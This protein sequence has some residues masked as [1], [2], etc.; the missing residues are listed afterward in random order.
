MSSVQLLRTQRPTSP[1]PSAHSTLSVQQHTQRSPTTAQPKR[2]LL[3]RLTHRHKN[4]KPLPD[5]PQSQSNSSLNSL[6]VNRR[7]HGRSFSKPSKSK[8][9][10]SN[11]TSTPKKE[12][13]LPFKH[14]R[15]DAPPEGSKPARNPN[16]LETEDHDAP[17]FLDTDT[18]N[19]EGIVDGRRPLM[20]PS[21]GEIYEGWPPEQDTSVEAENEE[22]GA[23]D[24]PES[25]LTNR[26][27]AGDDSAPRPTEHDNEADTGTDDDSG[28]MYFMR[29]LRADSTFAVINASLNSTVADIISIMGKKTFFADDLSKYHIVLRKQDTSRQ[30]GPKE[31]PLL[32]QKQLLMMAGY[33]EN[34]DLDDVGREDHGYLCRFTFLPSKMS[35][36]SSLEKDPNFDRTS[37]FTRV[38]L[39]GRNL[40]TIPITLYVKAGEINT[41]NLSRNLTLDIPKDFI[42]TC[43][44]LREIRYCSNEAEKLSPN[45]TFATRLQSL[46]VSNNRL[47]ELD[48]AELDK[49]H[50]LLSL[51]L[52]NNKLRSVP[53]YFGSFRALRSL[54]LSSNSLDSFPETLRDLPTLKDLDISFNQISNLGNLGTL[55]N[56]ERLLATNNKLSGPL[57]ESLANL[58]SLREIDARFNAITNIDVVSQLP[59]LETL[60]L[61][62]NSIS[63]FEGSFH[64]LEVLYLNHNP[65]TKF[66]LTAP[67][68]SL[69]VLNLASA[70]LSQLP[71]TLFPK[72]T[73]LTKL[74]INKNHFVSLSPQFGLLSKL[75]YLSVFKNELSRLPAEIGRLTELR[76]LDVHENNLSILP[77]EI[78]LARKLETLNVSSNVLAEF[79]KPGAT[80]PALPETPSV[81]HT[82]TVGSGPD[83]EELGRLEDFQLRRPSQAS[84]MF[85]NASSPGTT[86][87]KGSI[88]SHSSNKP[89]GIN[90]IPTS[91][92]INTVTPASRKDSTL[93]GRLAATFASSLRHLSLA[94]NRLEDDVF[95]E[96][97]LLSELRI[98]NLSFNQ[99]Y[100]VP[101]R[102]IRRW[103]NLTQ[104]YL[105]GNDLTSIPSEDLE[106]SSKLRVL[107]INNNKFQN[108]PAEIGN[109]HCLATLDVGSN[110]LKYNVSNWPYDWNWNSNRQLRFLNLSGN[111]RLEIKPAI[112]APVGRDNR[113]LT[114][115][116]SL[117]SLRVLGLMDVTL[118][119]P[120]VP[121]QAPDRRVRLTGSIIGNS[122]PYGMADTL[123]RNEHLS[124]LDMVAPSFRGGENEALI[125]L[126]D[127]QVLDSG[128]NR[129]ARFLHEKFKY[130][131]SEELQKTELNPSETPLDALR[132]TYLALNQKLATTTTQALDVRN[133]ANGSAAHRGSISGID[134]TNDDLNSGSVATV[135]Y[136]LNTKLYIS[137][138]GDAQALL[139]QTEAGHR[140]ITRK[141]DPASAD[142]RQRI[143]E[144]GGFVSRH[145]KLN[146]SLEVSRAFGYAHLAPCVIAAPHVTMHEITDSDEM[147]II[148]SK[149]LWDY[150]TPDFAVDVARQERNDAMRAAQRLR[151]IAIAFG[152]TGK[153]MVMVVGLSD[154][155]KREKARYRTSSM[156]LL[157]P[158]VSADD[159]FATV[160]KAKRGRDA[161]GDSKLA[162]LKDEVDAP[163]GDVVLVFTDIKNSTILWETYAVAMQSA[164][165]MH[166]ELMRRQLR[167]IGGY[168]VKTEGDA[169]M[170]AFP[171]VT[172]A[173]LWCFKIQTELLEVEWPQEILSSV[174]GEEM[175]DAEG[176]RIFRGLSVRMGIHWGRPVCEIDPVTKRMDYFGPMVNR[177]ARIES[178]ADGGQI[179]VSHDF[180]TETM[181][182]LE[183]N[184]ES[185]RNGSTGSEETLSD[186]IINQSIR[187]DLQ[188]LGRIGFEV[189]DLGYRTLK[190]LENPEHVHL[191][192][193]HSLA[194]RLI[195]QQQRAEAQS[196]A[197]PGP[198]H[199]AMKS[200]NSQLTIDTNN[201]WD[202]WNVSLRLEILCS[203][204]ENTGA[205]TLKAP[206]TALIERMKHGG[207]EITDR[208]LINLVEHQISRIEVSRWSSFLA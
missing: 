132:R 152:A 77:P 95:N 87:R 170:V 172:S 194:S 16:E 198:G 174:H 35:G 49:L 100:D 65:V 156:S 144:A 165:K 12:S 160:R 96:L 84:G 108:L 112:S 143:R 111:K 126:F 155:R 121:D 159:Y 93:S 158:S 142:E 157:G 76:Y 115:F 193:P 85:S 5:S 119:I 131:F 58:K 146:D 109:L 203:T 122:M 162:R 72:I 178:V 62:H 101:P 145:G 150:L 204:L 129:V 75:E 181:K 48:H 34:D 154:L 63:Q 179:C 38:D 27:K 73:G 135:I 192:Y 25:W 89:I 124:T 22:T 79:P 104:L 90:R 102:T 202:L 190:G 31:K 138:V 123:G 187:R 19:M 139:I 188:E 120:S 1:A 68:P 173:L 61:G 20:T 191:M 167:I 21:I 32:I 137:N 201:V 168:E 45:L 103:A 186:D 140:E 189:K 117:S 52:S 151:D 130:V 107:H 15:H 57:D 114:D 116:S 81:A 33:Q 98:L 80:L 205:R 148:A 97:V 180:L 30:L 196:R 171:T 42:Q 106:E 54:Y 13:R 7:E 185:D 147:I 40:I 82:P 92:T 175:I 41:L 50:N 99:L 200:P 6:P 184:I 141:H 56:L 37:R 2:S 10:G 125:G 118:T 4:E 44:Q 78:W 195:V 29:I 149:E 199:D 36:Y 24:A 166:N 176:G 134:L 136:L 28:P 182:T 153:I 17:F 161:V 127:G 9:D 46:D 69:S 83:F 163:V 18:T 53:S 3:N 23:W 43:T 64:C 206:D 59:C 70:K 177:A 71:E 133:Q 66:D 8:L 55:V 207:G 94:E 88:V 11:D 169:F 47:E 208:F 91:S 60:L 183:S 74:T 128:G 197:Q 67:V 110:M 39:T 113:D 164:I 105:S 14:K 26:N 86:S 51:R